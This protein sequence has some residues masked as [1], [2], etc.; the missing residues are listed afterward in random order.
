MK[1]WCILGNTEYSGRC[2]V[3]KTEIKCDNSG[4]KQ[5]IQHSKGNQHKKLCKT[6]FSSSQT[7]LVFKTVSVPA[8]DPGTS[9]EQVPSS[10]KSKEESKLFFSF[11]GEDVL[12][13]EI[14]WAVKCANSNISF[15]AS[16]GISD[17]FRAKFKCPIADGFSVGRTKLSYMLTVGLHPAFSKALL[18]DVKNSQSCYTIQYDETTQAQVKKQMDL[19]IRY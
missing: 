4:V 3:C 6:I 8:A 15:R 16:D 2:V 11:P 12:T 5:L 17:T 19:L 13:A 14:I 1:E 7:K 10:S 9:R 18:Y